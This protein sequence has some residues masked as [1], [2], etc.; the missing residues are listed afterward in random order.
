MPRLVSLALAVLPLV[1]LAASAAPAPPDARRIHERFAAYVKPLVDLDIFQGT[2]L[3]ARGDRIVYEQGY[4]P[5]DLEHGVANSPASVFRIAS[6]SKPLTEVAI[7]TLMEQGK[8][9]LDDPLAKFLPDFPRGKEITIEMLLAHRAGIPNVNSLP[10]DEEAPGGTN[11]LD[12]LVRRIA[13]MPL[14]FEPGA[15]RRY[16][17]GGYA[18]LAKVIERASGASYPEYMARAVFAPLEMTQTRHEE[19]GSL[20]PHRAC[21]YMARPDARHGQM[22]PPFQQMDTKE[23]GGSLVSTAGDLH[24]FLR[25]MNRD[26]VIRATT[27]RKL[28]PPDSTQS[29][30]GRCPGYNLWMIRDFAHDAD[31]VMLANDYSCGNAADIGAA[32]L[33]IGLGGSVAPPVWRADLPADSARCARFAGFYRAPAGALPYGEGPFEVRWTR[34]GLRLFES[35]T[36]IDYLLPQADGSFLARTYWSEVRFPGGAEAHAPSASI[37]PLWF[38]GPAVVASRVE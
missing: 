3:F 23:G 33:S 6:L 31:V 28:F 34:E 4:G 7:G 29:F 35:G 16:S 32:L 9:A 22:L 17:N 11:T 37:R 5:A 14:D 30:Q 12:S 21:G 8:L 13:R 18:V 24:R 2:V 20:V 27:W 25:A 1:P 26:N 38:T 15:R 36:P 10:Y 19:D